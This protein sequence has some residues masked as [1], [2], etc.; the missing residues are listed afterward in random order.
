MLS[1][2]DDSDDD[3]EC[4]VYDVDVNGGKTNGHITDIGGNFSNIYS[5]ADENNKVVTVGNGTATDE[6]TFFNSL[7]GQSHHIL[8]PKQQQQQL[9]HQQHTTQQLLLLEENPAHNN[10]NINNFFS[11]SSNTSPI[12]N[13]GLVV[14]TTV[15]HQRAGSSG[16]ENGI[17]SSSSASSVRGNN[18]ITRISPQYGSGETSPTKQ[19]DV[20]HRVSP[21]LSEALPSVTAASHNFQTKSNQLVSSALHRHYDS[22]DDGDEICLV[23]E[24]DYEGASTMDAGS[25]NRES[26]PLLGGHGYSSSSGGRD[27]NELTVNTFMGECCANNNKNNYTAMKGKL[28]FCKNVFNFVECVKLRNS[29]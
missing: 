14:T 8:Q 4:D 7:T 29:K 9:Q 5:D 15:Q 11:L 12:L 6:S 19:A 25:D 20:N 1:V 24:V 3:D 13:N 26:Q 18:N 10:S 16:S 2:D 21:L 17:V 22:A 23:P 27:R 28:L